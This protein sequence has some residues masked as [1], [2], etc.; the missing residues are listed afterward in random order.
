MCTFIQYIVLFKD[1]FFFRKEI[2]LKQ[3]DSEFLLFVILDFSKPKFRNMI[4]LYCAAMINYYD[5]IK[6]CNLKPYMFLLN[7]SL[8]QHYIIQ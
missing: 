1:N 5:T 2:T 3:I 7:A 4:A 6:Y 8:A